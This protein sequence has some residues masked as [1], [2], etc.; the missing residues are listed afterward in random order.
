METQPLLNMQGI[1]KSFPGVKALQNVDFDVRPGEIMALVGENGAGK[2]TLMKILNG[3]YRPDDGQINW[4]GQ[5]VQLNSPADSQHVG[6]SMIHQELALVPYLDA[7]KNIYL[8]R[9]PQLAPGI[10]NWRQLYADAQRNLDTLGL[11]VAVRTPVRLY[12]IAQQQMIEVAKALSMN[13]R[14]IVMDEPTSSLTDREVTTLFEQMRG[15]RERGVAIVFISHRM[16]EIFDICDRV[17]VLRDGELVGVE[18]IDNLTADDI[19][20]MMVGREVG[21]IYER[22]EAVIQD[23]VV[24]EVENLSRG[25]LV[26]DVSFRLHR[27]EILGFAGL[28]GAGRTELVETIF[29]AATPTAGT[30][31]LNGETV[32]ITHPSDAIRYGIGLVPEDRKGAGLFLRMSVA[33]NIVMSYLRD[34][35]RFI[36][37]DHG[38]AAS[39]SDRF[40]DELNVRTPS[41][42]QII[43][44][45][46]GGNQQKVVIAKWLTLEPQVLILDEP[47]RGIDVGA[48][49]EIYKLIHGLAASGVGVIM[50]SSEL[51]EVLGVADRVLVM[52]EGHITGEFNAQDTTQ[53]EIMQ[54]ATGTKAKREQSA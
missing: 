14:L 51:P 8:G 12:S 19:I 21:Q 25:D 32:N 38:R 40:I 47:T 4:D 16:D 17:T 28:V 10:V 24:L 11:D 45:L 29:G 30:I 54:A 15:L 34:L 26:R 9:E 6:I 36:F 1:S 50:I 18:N 3:I 39:I 43:G 46:S 7:G 13:A 2:S 22:G 31:R 53:D 33:A 37:I 5:T 52:H 48:K 23:K 41:R 27:G 20:Q 35:L 44:N 49:S 42:Q